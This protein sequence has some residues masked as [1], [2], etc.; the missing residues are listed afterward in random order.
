MSNRVKNIYYTIGVFIFIIAGF[1]CITYAT[2]YKVDISTRN[3][4]QTSM[5]V[6]QTDNADISLDNKPVGT[7]K[8]VLRDLKSGHY[9]IDIS[10]EGY[11]SWNRAID[12]VPGEAEIIDDDILFKTE[13]VPQEYTVTEPGFFAN[14]SD[15][16][17][18]STVSNELYQN[19]NFVTRF[20][21]EIKGVCWYSDRRY[22]AY[23]YDNHLKIIETDG[24][25]E[26][27]ILEKN[28]DTPAVFTNSGRSVVYENNGKVY[29][30]DIR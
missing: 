5:I 17:N 23:T 12:L 14:L 29:K 21:E 10:K 3:L 7:G 2:G 13:I 16:Q 18:L 6:V 26:V 28:S 19:S 25:N 27:L 4:V 11:H 22:I 8:V 15:A 24:T 20:T 1:F 9:N 30:A